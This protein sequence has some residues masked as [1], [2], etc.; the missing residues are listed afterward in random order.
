MNYTKSKAKNLI[1][2]IIFIMML[3][4]VLFL[5]LDQLYP[6]DKQRLS[7]PSSI[8]I[9]DKND[10]PLRIKLSQVGFWRLGTRKDELPLLLKK[11]VIYFEDRY[12][13]KHFGINPFSIVRAVYHN[14]FHKRIIG[15]STITMQVARMM[16]HRK[17]TLSNKLIEIFNALQLEWHYTKDDIL[18][19]YFNL[20]PYG[21]NIEGV[22]SAAL[23][24]F[25]KPLNELTISQI[26]ILTSI[27]KN[28]NLNRPDRQKDLT[29]KRDIILSKLLKYHLIT[30]EQYTRAKRE[31][32]T[33]KRLKVPF[34]APHFTNIIKTDKALI[35]TSLDLSLQLY[36]Q[37]RLKKQIQ[38]LKSFDL[39]N[40]AAL[41]IH[42]P[43]MQILAYIGSCDFF[44]TRYEGQ[45]NGI[46]MIRSPG[47]T[48]KPFIYAKALENGFITPNQEL[49]DIDLFL[50]GYTPK[51]FD[52]SF[53]GII[54]AK[55]ALQYSLNIPAISLNHLLKENSLYEVL[56]FANIRSI[57][58]KKSY[59]GDAIALGGC[60]ISL[61]DLTLLYTTLA[62]RGILK[63]PSYLLET[64]K[65]KTKRVFLESSSYL[66]STILSDA[67]R[68][69]L[70]NYWESTKNIP[71]VAFKTG[72]SAR[73]K[74][75][76]CVGYTP[77][78]TVGVWFG[79]FNSKKTKNLTG[80]QS[81]S[82]VVLDIF[83]HLNQKSKLSWFK[84]PANIITKMRCVDAIMQKE[85][86]RYTKDSLI[87][88]ITPSPPCQL[89]RAE[90]FAYL[91]KKHLITSI[92]DLKDDK[93][94][95]VWKDYNPLI[96]SPAN[97]AKII[98]NQLLPKTLNKLKFNCYSFEQNQTI[99]W[100]IDDKKKITSTSAKPIFIYL[101]EGNHQIN[102]LDM[103]S[104][105]STHEINILKN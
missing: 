9:L 105:I 82:E 32:I 30:K 98:Q 70:S 52:K 46:T 63:K 17:R 50:Q 54:S 49:Y 12:F 87:K 51:N 57:D 53:I 3:S 28:P 25:Q 36:A 62:N 89:I 40:G 42:N 7:K 90:T 78:Y 38:K 79:N 83:E 27:P 99:Y 21:G 41:I 35:K 71:K 64:S 18:T 5:F 55:E 15:A 73:A 66:I 84:K 22:K 88:G 45:N 104:K 10:I 93:C 58:H 8:M 96:T 56:K 47:S 95:K 67:S 39:H 31:A 48:L 101:P 23:F 100:F 97:G 80:L 4:F 24:Y 33:S 81:A 19:Y 11:S 75:L 6:L 77:E 1:Y 94:Y 91:I 44:D 68:M 59:Y 14:T 2:L 26:A 13:Y 16:Y 61:M 20:A 69:L 37:K 74:D 29:K 76:L 72:T 65:Q 103:A 85:C 92:N 60:G 86:K 34:Y 102:C 43:T